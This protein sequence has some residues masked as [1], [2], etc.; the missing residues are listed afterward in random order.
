MQ[1]VEDSHLVHRCRRRPNGV[2]LRAQQGCSAT[3]VISTTVQF[4]KWTEKLQV[5]LWF[6]YLLPRDRWCEHSILKRGLQKAHLSQI[7]EFISE[8]D[9]LLLKVDVIFLFKT[10]IFLESSLHGR[11][12]MWLHSFHTHSSPA[13]SLY[14]SVNHPGSMKKKNLL[15]RRDLV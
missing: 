14:S 4:Q 11:W 13:R 2:V 6:S 8:M 3:G 12:S 5:C 10:S 1:P 7:W 9:N 15:L